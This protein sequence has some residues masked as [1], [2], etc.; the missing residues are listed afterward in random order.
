MPYMKVFSKCWAVEFD[1]EG[2]RLFTDAEQAAE[3]GLLERYG[4]LP[5]NWFFGTNEGWEGDEHDGTWQSVYTRHIV[6]REITQAEYQR[7]RDLLGCRTEFGH[8]PS[9]LD[10]PM[11][12]LEEEIAE[13]GLNEEDK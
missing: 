10:E 8:Y 4:V 7:L 9:L 13:W 2:I 1:V 11:C 12:Y 6:V 5:F 3:A